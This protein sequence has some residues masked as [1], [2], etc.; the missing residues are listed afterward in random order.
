MRWG[1]YA[2]GG[3][4]FCLIT[5]FCSLKMRMPHA[6]S[7]HIRAIRPIRPI[8]PQMCADMAC[9]ASATD[10]TGTKKPDRLIGLEQALRK[11]AACAA[12]AGM[13]RPVGGSNHGR[14]QI[15]DAINSPCIQFIAASTNGRCNQRPIPFN[16]HSICGWR[17]GR[18]RLCGG[19]VRIHRQH[20]GACG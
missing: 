17:S 2:L 8:H 14:V 4:R 3:W 16:F 1:V 18:W 13:A 9:H 15:A 7:A 19:L 20:Q 6:S 11:R 10:S 5:L 12:H